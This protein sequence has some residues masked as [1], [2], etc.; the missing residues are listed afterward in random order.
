MSQMHAEI[1]FNCQRT[2]DEVPTLSWNYRGGQ[3]AVCSEC[4]P[5]LIHKLDQVL[6]A[7]GSEGK[8]AAAT[9]DQGRE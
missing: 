5:L 4:M 6:A 8:Q 9:G 7:L 2:S 1:C 3:L